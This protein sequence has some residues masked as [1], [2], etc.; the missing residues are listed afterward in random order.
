MGGNNSVYKRV[1]NLHMVNRF[2][3]PNAIGMVNCTNYSNTRLHI[4]VGSRVFG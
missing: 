3:Y 1:I 2:F 4:V